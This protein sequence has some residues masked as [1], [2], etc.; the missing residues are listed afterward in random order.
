MT[1]FVLGSSSKNSRSSRLANFVS[2][3]V[4]VFSQA[5]LTANK[6]SIY[7]F[8]A[9]A[10]CSEQPAATCHQHRV[11]GANDRI[12][13]SKKPSRLSPWPVLRQQGAK[14]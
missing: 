7:D 11:N 10:D 2:T 12:D 4:R 13:N 9:A 14:P 6:K 1:L 3:S 5:I 8:C